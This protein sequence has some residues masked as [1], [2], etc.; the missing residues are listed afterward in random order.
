MLRHSLFVFL[1]LFAAIARAAPVELDRILV[2]VNDDA[3]TQSDLD[4]R[5]PIVKRQLSQQGIPLPPDNVLRKQ[6]LERL[7]VERLQLQLAARQGVVVPDG[8]VDQAMQSLARQ[9]GYLDTQ[10]FADGLKKEGID[11]AKFRQL[12]REQLTIQMLVDR[13]INSRV[14][15]S[16]SEIDNFLAQHK[17]DSD[18]EYNV[19]HIVVRLP[20]GASQALVNAAR[21]KAESILAKLRAGADFEQTAIAE[22]QDT[23]ALEGGNLGWKKAGQ[24]PGLFVRA[25]DKMK[26]GEVSDVIQ[27]PGGF[28][29]L[30]LNDA[31]KADIAPKTVTQTHVRHILIKPS[32]V[33]SPEDAVVELEQLR[34]RL[35]NGAHF[36][37][38]ARAYS[39][40]LGSAAN[41][42]DLGWVNPGQLVPEFEQAMNKLAVNEVSKPVRTPYG[43][44]LIQV[45]GRRQ[46]DVTEE[47][48]RDAARAQI[49][50]RKADELYS[51]WLRQL[52]DEAFIEYHNE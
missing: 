6:L 5:L 16:D 7:I 14:T 20:E 11:P 4:D 51:Q 34:A 26:P 38:L 1:V 25:L 36:A 45:L 29:I 21:A 39:Q 32:A 46:R 30:R 41:G 42:G 19:S 44:H 22:S 17:D 33:M 12:V 9:N 49:H 3:I 8:R 23:N 31:R 37:A 13:D 28:H 2:V 15:V 40:D 27:S 52:R 10:G 35:E 18:N 50:A 43:Y 47:M 48:D 24:L